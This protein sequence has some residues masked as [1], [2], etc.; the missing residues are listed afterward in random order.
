VTKA[1]QPLPSATPDELAVA[2]AECIESGARI[3]NLSAAL[4]Q[5]SLS[6][7]RDLEESLDFAAR[8]RVHVVAAAGNQG[9]VGSSAITRHPWVIPVVAYSPSQLDVAPCP[10]CGGAVTAEGSAVTSPAYIYALGLRRHARGYQPVPAP[11][12]VS[13]SPTCPTT[14]ALPARRGYDDRA[15]GT[16]HQLREH[17]IVLML[18]RE[19]KRLVFGRADKRLETEERRGENPRQ[20]RLAF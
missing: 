16:P 8:R 7:E 15:Q 14:H 3:L 11:G 2:I 12:T 17:A 18:G 9:V 5:P 10:T 4:T 1:G 6:G 13:I 19:A 20:E